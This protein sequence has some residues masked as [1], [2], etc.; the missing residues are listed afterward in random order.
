VNYYSV[1]GAGNAESV[2]SS[3]FTIRSVAVAALQF[4]P[5]TP[6]R[7][8]DTRNANGTFGGPALVA[9]NTRA[10]P[11]RSS[12]CGIPANAMAYSVNVT[13]AP[14]GALGYLT[15]WPLGTSQPT[16]STLNSDGRV[17]AN[18]A[19]VPAGSDSGGSVNVYVTN[20]THFILDIDGYFVQA[21]STQNGLQFYSLAPCRVADTRNSNGALGGPFIPAGGTRS[22]PVNTA[23]NIPASAT[24]YSLN[25]TAVPHGSLT[26]ITAWPQGQTQPNASV[27]NAP[28]GTVVANAA[29]IPAGSP[30]GGVSVFASNDTDM[31]IDIDGYF[32]PPGSGG[33]WLYTVAPCRVIDTR[34]GSGAFT[35]TLVVNVT[36]SSCAPSAA[37]KSFVLNATVVPSGAL[38]YLTLWADGAT[39]PAVSTLNAFDGAVTSNMALVPTTNGKIDAYAAANTNLILDISGYFAP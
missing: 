34:S 1:D 27:L 11:V 19:I 37:A 18:A 24:A 17:K 38:P 10:F 12:A 7:V 35:G 22:F 2:K 6:C 26:Y 25:F 39:Q 21:G 31:I 14:S 9:N 13:V 36:G 8:A 16:A 29:I 33:L 30:N 28:T 4:I 5:I 15:I 20:A 3:S 32:A 23:C